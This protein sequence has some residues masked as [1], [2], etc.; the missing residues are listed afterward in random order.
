MIHVNLDIDEKFYSTFE[1]I[2]KG[3]REEIKVVSTSR[4]NEFSNTLKQSIA[5]LKAGRVEEV[6]D[7]DN[8]FR[9]LQNEINS[10]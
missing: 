8:H 9:E 3:F 5:D 4:N 2:I 6:E 10:D 1:K 7:L